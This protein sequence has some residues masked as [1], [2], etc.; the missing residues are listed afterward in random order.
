MCLSPIPVRQSDGSFRYFPCGRCLQCLHNYQDGICARLNE[1][2]N[3]WN[4]VD[5]VAPCV[6]FTLDYRDD[7]IPC[8]YLVVNLYSGCRVQFDK[9]SCP[10]RRYWTSTTMES[11]DEW[12]SRRK[13]ILYE[14]TCSV[15]LV[16]SLQD[17]RADI[18]DILSHSYEYRVGSR[19]P[20]TKYD[21]PDAHVDW[22]KFSD[23]SLE[24][25]RFM[26]DIIRDFSEGPSCREGD[27]LAL[28]FHS[29]C[30]KDVQGWL[31]RGRSALSYKHPDIFGFNVNPRLKQSFEYRG[32]TYS[33]PSSS[34]TPT[35][36]YFITSEY[37]PK[38]E[39]P[40]YH[41]VMFGITYDE[42][43]DS[44]AADWENRFGHCVFSSLRPSGGAM[45]YVSKY[46]SKG[47]YEHRYC[48]KN[49]YYSSGS[50]YFSKRYEDCLVDF[51][52]DCPMVT[53]TFRLFSKGL[54]AA[55]LFKPSVLDSFNINLSTIYT[56]SGKLRYN[57]CTSSDNLPFDYCMKYL[58][59]SGVPSSYEVSP[60]S[61]N[62]ILIVRKSSVEGFPEHSTIVNLDKF[63]DLFSFYQSSKK[64]Y[65]R[66]FLIEKCKSFGQNPD[67]WHLNPGK[68]LVESKTYSCPLPRYFAKALRSPVSSFVCQF[69]AEMQ[70]SAADL[71]R[72]RQ[73]QFERQAHRSL[74]VVLETSIPEEILQKDT[75]DRLR[76]SAY[77]FFN[78]SKF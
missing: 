55:Y 42:F 41:G 23:S 31:K 15:R 32:A 5:S 10:V 65:N 26:C 8:S 22:Y 43:K 34:L 25:P 3:H 37:G 12:I 61:G 38:T 48:R 69:V 30:R 7:C 19:F 21:L 59:P 56:P 18:E 68:T 60:L 64:T 75:A 67:K 20:Y 4:K 50:T 17:K 49:F 13:K 45:L 78:R 39:R 35:V 9:P 33:Y 66:A 2:L 57:F 77:N 63:L 53:P 47:L 14:Y 72:K 76:R 52:L 44:F 40:H 51:G 73:I 6:F 58:P 27:Y 62:R 74:D 16:E 28:E 24:H 46:C 1:E 36:K 29:V 70:P 71:Q 54:G 11:K